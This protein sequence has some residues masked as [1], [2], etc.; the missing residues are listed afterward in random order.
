MTRRRAPTALLLLLLA[1]P[2]AGCGKPFLNLGAG[3]PPVPAESV[4]TD[5]FLI[6]D[7]GHPAPDGEPVLE[8]LGRKVAQVPG[9]AF[10]VFLGDN[11]YPAGLPEEGDPGRETAEWI[12]REQMEPLLAT[13]T[14]GI[15]L[16]GNHDWGGMTGRGWEAVIRQARFVEAHGEGLIDYAPDGGCPGPDVR[17]LGEHLRLI[18]VDTH[19]WIHEGP[20]PRFESECPV[21]TEEGLVDALRTALR[22]AWLAHRQAIV[23]AH[24]PV[25]SGGRHGGYFDWP[26]YLFPVVPWARLG[27]YFAQ[28]DV[29]GEEYTDMRFSL[30]RAFAEHPPLVYAAGHE[31]N[32][33]VLH[34]GPARYLLVSGGGIYGHTTPV[35]AITGT[36]YANAAS[37]FMRLTALRDGRIR[38]GVY[39]VDAEGEA[40]EDFST[41]LTWGEPEETE[42][43]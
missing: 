30:A 5:L 19:W 35:R 18:V 29:T 33:Q 16:P 42:R 25:A 4:E 40:R 31:H 24:H 26:S 15:F 10:V 27:G 2:L 37:G 9:R 39:V 3:L 12:L 43:R 32:L 20:K 13:G 36:Q 14:P 28:Q 8:A 34:R 7:A 23:V 1:L 38:L 41:W 11:V 21:D 6:G 17:D 22:E